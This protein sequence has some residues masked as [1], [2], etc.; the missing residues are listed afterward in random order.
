MSRAVTRGRTT[1]KKHTSMG[2]IFCSRHRPRVRG[3]TRGHLQS[4]PHHCAMA[5]IE[6]EVIDK[7]LWEMRKIVAAESHFSSSHKVLK[8]HKGYIHR[9]NTSRL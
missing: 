9:L 3:L 2:Y 1:S 7:V 5:W 4:H 8:I 6:F